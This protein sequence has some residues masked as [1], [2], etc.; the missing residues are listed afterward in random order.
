[1]S[2][3]NKNKYISVMYKLYTNAAG[4]RPELVEETAEGEPFV[5]VSALGM[6]LD[7]FEAQIVPLTAGDDFNFTLAPA[8][9]YGEYE[10]TG[11]QAVPRN[12]FEINGKLDSR[13]IYVGA[14][15]PL[16]S[17][18]GARFNG[19]I[20]EIGK[21]TVTV[22]INHPLAGKSLNFVGKVLISREATNDEVRDALNQITGC[23]GGCGGC[24]GGSCDG[25]G[26][27]GE[28]CGGCR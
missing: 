11:R 8:D 3:E 24:G 7:A 26:S 13:F 19:T 22:D 18:D 25:C 23:G 1:M 6:T 4:D 21:E 10:P 27:K 9:A 5:F 16:A 17:P 28:G 20:V 15:V 14:V 2:T 12:I